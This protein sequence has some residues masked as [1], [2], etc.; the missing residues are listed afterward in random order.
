MRGPVSL[1]DVDELDG[2]WIGSDPS[3]DNRLVGQERLEGGAGREVAIEIERFAVGDLDFVG[4][5]RWVH[6]WESE[7]VKG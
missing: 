4:D 3:L 2:S 6:G 5:R 1:R 7:D